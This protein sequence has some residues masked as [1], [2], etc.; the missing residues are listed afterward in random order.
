MIATLTERIGT[1]LRRSQEHFVV[2]EEADPS[3]KDSDQ[4]GYS[5]TLASVDHAEQRVRFGTTYRAHDIQNVRR[6]ILPFDRG[7]VVLGSRRAT[8]VESIA[9]VRRQDAGRPIDEGELDTLVFKALWEFLNRYRAWAAKK[10]E[11][12]DLDLALASIEVVDV[13]I[14]GHRLLNPIGFRGSMLAVGFRGTFVPRTLAALFERFGGWIRELAVT[15]RGS[16]LASTFCSRVGNHLIDIGERRT[17]VFSRRGEDLVYA[18]G[19]E[20]GS[21]TVIDSVAAQFRCSGGVARELLL[22]AARGRTSER[23]ARVIDRSLR[24]EAL[25][26]SEFVKS[27]EGK[28][29]PSAASGGKESPN[30]FT[31]HFRTPVP[32][33]SAL[34]D[35][36][37]ITLAGVDEVL[38]ARGF[39]MTGIPAGERG[40]HVSAETV[41][42]VTYPYAHREYGIL[43]QLLRRRARWLISQP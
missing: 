21:V 12:A 16:H 22:A 24:A 20:W 2:I 32:R 26:L 14:D 6:R 1:I 37:P 7:V 13:S 10:M 43:N 27:V 4:A 33:F 34:L 18:R 17:M 35:R 39:T 36:T 30:Q 5:V 40:H 42:A 19:F 15:E 23:F 3:S 9:R 11:V 41:A 31:A 25:K 8:T 38:A 29:K 28:R